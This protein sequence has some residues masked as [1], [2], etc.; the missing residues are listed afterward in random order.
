[1]AGENI[2]LDFGQAMADA[3]EIERII[4]SIDE[5]IKVLN[6]GFTRTDGVTQLDWYSDMSANWNSFAT[7]DIPATLE[8]MRKS[9][10]NIENAVAAMQQYEK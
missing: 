2:T 7:T 3:Q 5:A 6:S 10:A 8:E 1:M 9:K 4:N